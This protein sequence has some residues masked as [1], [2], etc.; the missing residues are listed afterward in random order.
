MDRSY[1][2][3]ATE[4]GALY[5]A[6]KVCCRGVRWK[7]S[8]VGYEER[9]LM[10]SVELSELLRNGT[11]K[12]SKYQRFE[13]MEPK[14]REIVAARLVDR[15]FQR[16]LCD[17]GLYED[18]TEHFTADNCACQSGRGTDYAMARLKSQLGA[19]HRRHGD[20]G[21][22][23]KCDVRHFFASIPHDVAKCAITKRVSDPMAARAV[24]DVIDSFGGDRGLGLGSQ[25]SQL[26]ALA[27]LDDMDHMVRERLGVRCY[28]RYMDDFILVH[29]DKEH[30]RSCLD[31][32]SRH[33][34]EIGLELNGKTTMQPLRHGIWF[35]Q[36]RFVITRTGRVLVLCNRRKIAKWK[37]RLAAIWSRETSGLSPNGTTRRVYE[38]YLACLAK[39]DARRERGMLTAFYEDLTGVNYA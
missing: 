34:S 6:L 22:Y 10:H 29:E 33:L 31:A 25:I 17:A 8:V 9:G 14:R 28:V 32:I 16:A 23:L 38:C 27:V 4:P 30:L 15:Q 2:H 11:Y 39:G 1:W 26:T 3:D 24:C 13:V 35:L 20:A 36:W 12:I 5:D 21:W 37:R 19:Y 7:D 18:I